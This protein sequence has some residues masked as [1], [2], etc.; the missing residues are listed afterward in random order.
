MKKSF[1]HELFISYAAIALLSIAIL[2][3]FLIGAVQKKTE[4][5]YEKASLLEINDIK[6]TITGTLVS[7]ESATT[8]IGANE[9]VI[10]A[11]LKPE[12]ES[13]QLAYN[14]LY[15]LTGSVRD[16]V[17]FNIY[18]SLGQNVLTTENA[19]DG[20]S[21][22]VYWGILKSCADKPEKFI[23]RSASGDIMAG[24]SALFM[25]KAIRN[26]DITVGFVVASVSDTNMEAMLSGKYSRDSELAIIDGFWENIYSSDNAN[27]EDFAAVLRKA[28]FEGTGVK[29]LGKDYTY[30]I[31][32]LSGKE[33]YIVL[34][35]GEVFSDSLRRT[36]IFVILVVAAITLVTCFIVSMVLTRVVL[37]PLD[38]MTVAMEKVR[39][40][41]LSVRINSHRSDE[42]G[43]LSRDFDDMTKALKVYVELRSK[44][45]QELSDS[46]IAMMQ[47][48]LNP[49]F[50]YNTL[51]TVKWL[52][53]A[54]NVPELAVLSSSLATILRASISADIFVTLA[55]EMNLVEKYVDIQKI[56]FSGKFSFDVELPMELEDAIVP[57]LILQPLVENA[58]VHGLK[59]ANEGII[60]INVYSKDGR[61]IVAVED[62]GCGMDSTM[63]ETLNNRDRNKLKGHLGFYNVDTII[64]LH[65]GLNYGLHAENLKTGGV[66]ITMELPLNFDGKDVTENG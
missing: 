35:R 51:D 58:I 64:R 23:I 21:R 59:E 32:Q 57:K 7:V 55:E 1:R 12:S 9:A 6:R 8:K 2:G 25:A 53:K 65:Y 39:M 41:D 50:L 3:L 60:F 18:D 4:Y 33:I 11:L 26:N 45:Q 42:F 19:S 13:V 27:G 5:D 29:S 46:N 52:A 49:H 30:F 47:A 14:E 16:R 38:R 48:Q 43:Q 15:S 28:R 31:G 62:N 40:G 56:R 66:K 22:P 24:G 17:T 36:M 54:N 61:L 63:L 20:A 10:E 37:T 44:Q 34:G